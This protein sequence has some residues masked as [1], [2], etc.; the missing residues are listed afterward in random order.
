ML[1]FILLAF[2]ICLISVCLFLYIAKKWQLLDIPNKRSS[3]SQVTYRGGGV[4]FLPLIFYNLI[5][6]IS[7]DLIWLNLALILISLIGLID[8][9]Y[10]L[11]PSLRSFSYITFLALGSYDIFFDIYSL[12]PYAYLV[13]LILGVAVIN[14]WNFM[15]G[16]NGIT[17]L[18]TGV[19]LL[20]FL[21]SFHIY[22]FL[23]FDSLIAS[24]GIGLIGFSV[25]NLRKKPIAFLGD[26]G[27]ILL[28]MFVV[29]C[30]SLLILKTN[31]I[32]FLL[33]VLIYGLDS[34][35][36]FSERLFKGENVFK[37]HRTHLYQYLANEYK[38][39][40]LK[41]SFI[42]A[43]L[44]MIINALV[45]FFIVNKIEIGL[46]QTMFIILVSSIVYISFKQF[47]Y[48]NLRIKYSN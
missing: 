36:T 13:W 44:Q 34:V 7:L 46:Y 28:G 10:T 17:V 3:H 40:H 6:N 30:L 48:R 38:W 41:V 11:K 43:L 33:F 29:I 42:Y 20:S 47:I 31:E 8:D 26:V 4:I 2:I 39:S 5:W 27:S 16:I 15:D 37:A 14:A 19:V 32:G 1:Y 12:P 35:I 21:Y 25:L 22:N 45:I 9:V 23:E 24:I 18:Y